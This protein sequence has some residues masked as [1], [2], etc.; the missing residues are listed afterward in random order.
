M[1]PFNIT[2]ITDWYKSLSK[3]TITECVLK[4]A[5]VVE[6]AEYRC[7][8][9]DDSI[10]K[11]RIRHH[12][13]KHIKTCENPMCAFDVMVYLPMDR[14]QYGKWRAMNTFF[15]KCVLT[16]LGLHQSIPR[17]TAI[18]T[19]KQENIMLVSSHIVDLSYGA[20]TV[21]GRIVKKIDDSLNMIL[22]SD[23]AE[24]FSICLNNTTNDNFYILKSI[25]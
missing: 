16:Q 3:N 23:L 6:S 21:K 24:Q 13:N 18:D 14:H 11:M 7:Q 8:M 9:A 19:D 4:S 12:V 10:Q 25:V 22:L 20:K 17:C 1:V 5:G 15:K 2:D